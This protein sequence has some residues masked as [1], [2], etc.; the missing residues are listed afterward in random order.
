MATRSLRVRRLISS[1]WGQSDPPSSAS[2]WARP[3][4]K[5]HDLWP[6]ED[7]IGSAQ[8]RQLQVIFVRVRSS[9][10]HSRGREGVT[11][12][13]CRSRSYQRSVCGFR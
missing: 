7:W 1:Q 4:Q 11:A 13:A 8:E 3:R 2:A 12:A 5:T 10:E 6:S 9:L